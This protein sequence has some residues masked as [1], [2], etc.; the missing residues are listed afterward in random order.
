MKIKCMLAV[1]LALIFTLPALCDTNEELAK[2][3]SDVETAFANTMATRDFDG[4]VSFLS[5]E[6]VFFG[7]KSVRRGKAVVAA[8]WKPFFAGPDA[9]FSWKPEKVEVLDSGTLALSTG[10]V[11]APDG[12]QS[13]TYSSIWRLEAD[14]KWRIIFDQ[15]CPACNCPEK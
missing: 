3:V 2:R 10:P 7:G 1:I 8:A 14:G 5:D 4:F 6:T 12:K 15:G 9:P 11:Y 13:G